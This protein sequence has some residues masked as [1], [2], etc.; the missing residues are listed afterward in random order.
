LGVFIPRRPAHEFVLIQSFKSSM[1]INNTFG[2]ALLAKEV[3][4]ELLE[5]EKQKK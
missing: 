5:I 1:E 2:F 4:W 3:T